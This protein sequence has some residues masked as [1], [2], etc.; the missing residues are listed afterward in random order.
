MYTCPVCA[1]H[2]SSHSLTK[3]AEKNGIFYFYTCPAKAT[4]YDVKGILAHYDGV[5]SEIPE[6]KEWIWIFDSIGFG[7]T[8]AMQTNVAIELTNLISTKFSKNLK[9]IKIINPTVYIT[10]MHT[11]LM[12]FLN[13]TLRDSIEMCELK[14]AEEVYKN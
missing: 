2:P 6:N 7:I 1:V 14:T 10:M 5:L 9:K 13:Q 11:I 12:P 4:V 8:H 3:V